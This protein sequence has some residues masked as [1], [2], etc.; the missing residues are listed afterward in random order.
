ML[1]S[2]KSI[3]PC[4][5]LA[6][7]V[8]DILTLPLSGTHLIEASAGTGKTYTAA[9][10]VLRLIL[11]KNLRLRDLAV[12]TFTKPAAA[13][14]A[15][16]IRSL[17]AETRRNPGEWAQVWLQG[18][19]P[20][21][22]DRRLA[23]AEADVDLATISTIHGFCAQLLKEFSFELNVLP[24]FEIVEDDA[25]LAAAALED[26]WRRKIS[27]LAPDRL[28]LVKDLTPPK[29]YEEIKPLLRFPDLRVKPLSFR[30]D[31]WER[32]LALQAE[33][34]RLWPEARP[35]LREFLQA[36]ISELDGR[37]FKET[38]IE[39]YL[40]NAQDS[41]EALETNEAFLK[42]TKEYLQRKMHT[43]AVV[44]FPPLP[45]WECWEAADPEVKAM[46]STGKAEFH[47]SI[48]YEAYVSLLADLAAQKAR[49]NIKTYNDLI[50]EVLKGL[51]NGGSAARVISQRFSAV[52]IDEFQDTD[53]AQVE[54]FRLFMGRDDLFMAL[55]GDPKQAIYSFRGG[56]LATYL[57]VSREIP[58]DHHWTLV[59]NFRSEKRLLAAINKVYQTKIEN[60]VDAQDQG[61]FMT[62]EIAFEALQAKA[63]LKPVLY[64]GSPLP[65]LT[66]WPKAGDDMKL[67]A[68]YLSREIR[69][70]THATRGDAEAPSSEAQPL[71]L[72]DMA[73]LVK[74]HASAQKLQ[75]LLAQ[76][77]IRT[78]LGRSKN[79]LASAEA[80]DLRLLIAALLAPQDEGLLRS[81]LVSDLFGYD[82]RQLASWAQ[83][84]DQIQTLY[85]ELVHLR[86]VWEKSGAGTALERFLIHHGA[87]G[88]N[89]G[90]ISQDR[91]HTN[92][93]HLLEILQT[94]DRALARQPERTASWFAGKLLDGEEE[95]ELLE[96][97]EEAVQIVTMHKAKGLQWPVVFAVELWRGLNNKDQVE[98]LWREG[99][100]LVGD[101]DPATSDSRKTQ[102]K[103]AKKQEAQRLAYVALTRAESLLYVITAWSDET[104][105]NAKDPTNSPATWLLANPE[106]LQVTDETGPL[107][108]WGTPPDVAPRQESETVNLRPPAWPSERQIH[109]A[110]SIGSYTRL[111]GETAHR[112]PAG[113]PSPQGVAPEGLLA[114]P[115]GKNAGLVLHSIYEKLDFMGLEGG[116]LNAEE[117]AK[118]EAQLKAA[119]P[120]FEA[121]SQAVRE[122]LAYTLTAPLLADDPEFSLSKLSRQDR[123]TEV[124]F[125]LRAAHPET[126]KPR[127]TEEALISLLGPG[128]WSGKFSLQGYL[129][130]FIDLVFT[131]KKRWY[132]LDW[133]SNFLGSQTED[134]HPAAL[135]KAMT[136]NR[137]HLQY[138][139]Y[140]TAWWRH[141]GPSQPRWDQ[142]G[143][144]LYL[145]LR[146]LSPRS[147]GAGIYFTR[148]DEAVIRG[149]EAL[150]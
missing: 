23:L 131:W 134:Y 95:E 34:K 22:A 64:Q 41:F 39:T 92:F 106:L 38:Q 79:V 143:G 52:M 132:I 102:Q 60:P 25:P 144:V 65:P 139:L 81:L 88:L 133:K 110:W 30:Q 136:E 127:L 20:A 80:S 40:E 57:K 24:G 19:D 42:I 91:R 5:R 129:H 18:L 68:D 94:Q 66:F 54:I 115:K 85:D 3:S 89:A 12:V 117:S 120:Q 93:R 11:E 16:R 137:Y 61:P 116:T 135:E 96:S 14:L 105:G 141:L 99:H 62:T 148:P 2:N 107:L 109:E 130:G 27:G 138:L 90:D 118:A 145:F 112:A 84:E 51:R 114:F 32:W 55:I 59:N 7:A 45:F 108:V 69:R 58:A 43:K 72:R 50:G 150:L 49:Q 10:L 73:I 56:D 128:D 31:L 21:E 67:A 75:G 100:T 53:P 98:P 15:Q 8:L 97:D 33:L 111:A 103:T 142:F 35:A 13:E 1:C 140:S 147:P 86:Q 46:A 70:L 78:V 113:T 126:N 6:V 124:E 9:H 17:V 123:A 28:L 26:F 36:N 87:F 149:L 122:S 76:Q 29:L 104:W 63:K 121:H 48:L 44:D 119:G 4:W 125:Y 83:D 47:A 37:S 71:R 101:L 74:S 82:D 77:G 146:G